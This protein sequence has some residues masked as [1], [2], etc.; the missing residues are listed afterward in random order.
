MEEIEQEQEEWEEE[1]VE[2]DEEEPFL[3][4]DGAGGPTVSVLA[5]RCLCVIVSCG[6][7]SIAPT[8]KRLVAVSSGGWV[9]VGGRKPWSLRRCCA[10][11]TW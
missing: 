10:S 5:A 1:E 4:D 9:F 11:C 2:Q 3:G 6:R 8:A 7:C